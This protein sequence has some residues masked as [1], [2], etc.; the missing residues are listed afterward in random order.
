M[1][2][3]RWGMLVTARAEILD[4]FAS[5]AVGRVEY[6]SAFP[7]QVEFSVWLGTSTDAEADRLR[8]QSGVVV[9]VAE[10]LR[11]VGFRDAELAGLGVVVQSQ[12]T[13]E[14]DCAGNWF[15]ALR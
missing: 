14:R 4:A 7:D 5:D 15:Y 8:S 10:V 9:R 13:V 12:E 3:H 1:A 11:R 6:V 2:D